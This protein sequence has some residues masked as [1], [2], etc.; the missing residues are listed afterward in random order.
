MAWVWLF[1]CFAF[2]YVSPEWRNGRRR[3]LKI[4]RRR[5]R[6]GSTPTSGTNVT[7]I[8]LVFLGDDSNPI[9]F[10]K[11]VIKVF[12]AMYIYGG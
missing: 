8:H 9:K 6:V 10:C 4:L 2:L 11:G 3:G 7:L 1:R 5:L 12:R